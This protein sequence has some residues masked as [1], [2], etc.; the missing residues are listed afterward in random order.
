MT[1]SLHELIR[2]RL[3]ATSESDIN[4]KREKEKAEEIL[5]THGKIVWELEFGCTSPKG[6]RIHNTLQWNTHR[7]AVE[8]FTASIWSRYREVTFGISLFQGTLDWIH[9]LY[10]DEAQKEHFENW[11]RVSKIPEASSCDLQTSEIHPRNQDILFLYAAEQLSSYLHRLNAYL[12]EESI[13]FASFIAPDSLS[14]WRMAQALSRERFPYVLTDMADPA[15]SSL[16]TAVKHRAGTA[17]CLPTDQHLT[18]KVGELWE[19]IYVSL[20]KECISFRVIPE[21]FIAED[22][23]DLGEIIVLTDS[24]SEFGRRQLEGFSISGG[25]IIFYGTPLDLPNSISWHQWIR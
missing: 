3:N 14:I 2:I 23:A 4:W 22:W 16:Y 21:I 13:C 5:K 12:P 15:L 10:W 24:L 1:S 6:F 19:A 17:L 25:K 20:Q 8:H 7:F 11:K 9:N 18:A